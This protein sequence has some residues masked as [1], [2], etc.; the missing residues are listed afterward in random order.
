M[1]GL[2]V[3][4]QIYTDLDCGSNDPAQIAEAIAGCQGCP[5]LSHCE[6]NKDRIR[7]ELW[8][9]GVQGTVFAAEELT[10]SYDPP[11]DVDLELP[12]LQFNVEH[13]PRD[14]QR[15]LYI[16]RQ[17]VRADQLVIAS[18]PPLNVRIIAHEYSQRLAERHPDLLQRFTDKLSEIEREQALRY[19]AMILCQQADFDSFSLQERS[20]SRGADNRRYRPETHDYE[21]NYD[22][23]RLYIKEVVA[24]KQSGYRNPG[25]MALHHSADYSRRL[26]KEFGGIATKDNFFAVVQDHIKDPN[27]ALIAYAAH[28][29]SQRDAGAMDHQ[30]H[31]RAL[32]H[33]PAGTTAVEAARR[34]SLID[35][36]RRLGRATVDKMLLHNAD[37]DQALEDL[38]TRID[39]ALDI[40]G[41]DHEI[42]TLDV[43]TRLAKRPYSYLEDLQKYERNVATITDRYGR[44]PDFTDARIRWMASTY[45]ANAPNVARQY[46]ARLKLWR[47]WATGTEGKQYPVPDSF[48]PE[49]ALAGDVSCYFDIAK[50]HTLKLLTSKFAAR[51]GRQTEEYKVP[52][53]RWMLNRILA[54]YPLNE[55]ETV[56]DN[57]FFALGEGFLTESVTALSAIQ[58]PVIQL[59]IDGISDPKKGK[60]VTFSGAM[61]RL[62]S[63][64][65]MALILHLNLGRLVYGT[66]LV[67]EQ[68]GNLLEIAQPRDH[69]M[70][71]LLP[72]ANAIIQ[73]YGVR[74]PVSLT[75][76]KKDVIELLQANPEPNADTWE[77]EQAQLAQ[78]VTVVGADKIMLAQKE[79]LFR[80][81]AE[82][83]PD[84]ARRWLVYVINR[85]YPATVQPQAHQDIAHAISGGR[86]VVTRDN[87]TGFGIGLSD[88]FYGTDLRDNDRAAVA[89][90]MGADRLLYKRNLNLTLRYLLGTPDIVAYVIDHV[91]PKLTAWQSTREAIRTV[92]CT[93]HA[94]GWLLEQESRDGNRIWQAGNRIVGLSTQML[95]EFNGSDFSSDPPNWWCSHSALQYLARNS[96][97]TLAKIF[98]TLQV[99]HEDTALYRLIDTGTVDLFYSPRVSGLVHDAVN[100]AA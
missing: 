52:V 17:A 29:Q 46:Q 77:A 41:P 30:A 39:R 49:Y 91:T 76:I 48:L 59:D 1:P 72:K 37:P 66:N 56:A 62:N 100:G 69:A 38:E 70:A 18:R 63:K 34:Q 78:R 80:G 75:V 67:D 84:S 93:P 31:R 95:H 55:V 26:F 85:R 8:K 10:A 27:R 33:R 44:N 19:I 25:Q 96:G 97:K 23:V 6:A 24:I 64:E 57:L 9:Q 5:Q 32:T 11:V 21:D 87:Q 14:S 15:R 90:V 81:T 20:N 4:D 7:D 71:V 65:R 98:A 42:V 82:V 22:T 47:D 40:Y 79:S 58:D 45:L 28:L 35:Q 60:Y 54:L 51:N 94:L 3:I 89:H 73:R 13:V 88:A 50:A 53:R 83:L 86:L 68:V 43:I 16:L 61:A 12:I 99:T 92:G 2:P 36:H 74:R